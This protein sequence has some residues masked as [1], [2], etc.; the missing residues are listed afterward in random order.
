MPTVKLKLDLSAT[1][2]EEALRNFRHFDLA[3]GSFFGLST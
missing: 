3:D 1:V 2:G